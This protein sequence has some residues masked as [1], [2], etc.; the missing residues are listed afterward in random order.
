MTA[1]QRPGIFFM[2]PVNKVYFN[3]VVGLARGERC[4]SGVERT[5]SPSTGTSHS[6]RG[7]PVCSTNGGVDKEC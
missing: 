1:L 2:A 3:G 4:P 7:I 5:N 6:V